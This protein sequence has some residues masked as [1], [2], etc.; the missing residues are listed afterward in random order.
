MMIP[1]HLNKRK[2]L[3][4]PSLKCW[5]LQIC[6]SDFPP[7]VFF[8][9]PIWYPSSVGFHLLYILDFLTPLAVAAKTTPWPGVLWML[10]KSFCMQYPSAVYTVLY[11]YLQ[12]IYYII[13]YIIFWVL[14]LSLLS[15]RIFLGKRLRKLPWHHVDSSPPKKRATAT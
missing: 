14:L 9:V 13:L 7:S 1:N 12:N 15:L 5:I 11:I 10:C 6:Y 3:I 2:A 4:L 8:R